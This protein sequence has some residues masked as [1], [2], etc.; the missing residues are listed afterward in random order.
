MKV[1]LRE[2]FTNSSAVMITSQN[3]RLAS[4]IKAICN[5]RLDGLLLHLDEF[6]LFCAKPGG[7][8]LRNNPLYCAKYGWTTAWV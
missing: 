4:I 7:L 6:G 3:Q 8:G 5:L 2:N 1:P